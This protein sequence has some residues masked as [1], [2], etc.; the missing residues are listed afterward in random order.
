MDFGLPEHIYPEA[1]ASYAP[2]P[3]GYPASNPSLA[4]ASSSIRTTWPSQR[5]LCLDAN[6]LHNV[7]VHKECIKLTV[8][9]DAEIIAN[10]P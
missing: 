6:T 7:H 1:S 9:L 5:T 3:V 4:R 10:S 8:G 2:M